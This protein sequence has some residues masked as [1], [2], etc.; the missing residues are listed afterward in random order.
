MFEGLG[1]TFGQMREV[2]AGMSPSRR[3]MVLG[4][5]A[6][7]LAAFIFLM[8]WANK[9]EYETVYAQLSQ[10]DAGAIVAK[11]KER[12]IPYQLTGNGTVI[13]VPK[14]AT[15]ET[16]LFLATEGLP[17][18]GAVGMEVFDR[19]ALGATDFVQR[20]N[21]QRALQ[22]EL[23]RTIRKF[24]EVD[25]VRVHL[26]IPKES[27]F[28]EEARE[29]SASVVLKLKSG[30]ALDR[31]Q[32]AG[33]VHLVSSS[34]EG[35][36]PQN[37]SVVDTQGGLLYSQDPDTDG[38]L[39]TEKQVQFRRNLEKTLADRVTT[40]LERVVGPN[41]AM[42][43]VTAEIS[44][45][46]TSTNEEIYDPDRTAIR[47][48]QRFTETTSGAARGAAGTP[49]ARYDLGTG[50]GEPGTG[51]AAE[52]KYQKNEETT[53]YEITKINR[54]T[55]TPGGEVQRLSVAVIVDGTYKEEVVDGKDVKTFV[56]R[57]QAEIT[58]LEQLV[59]NAVGY[60]ET[61]G[62]AVVVNSVPF[63]L[64]EEEAPVGFVGR[65]VDYLRQFG[66]PALNILLIV[67]FFLFVVRPIMSWVRKEAR[68]ALPAPTEPQALLERED[69]PAMVETRVEPG[70]L[71]REQVLAIAN[72]NPDRTVNMIRAWID[73]R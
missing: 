49:N 15:Q 38:V 35:L 66:R 32:L 43:R 23:E 50:Q 58:S 12:K 53:N 3:I 40:M 25:Q 28:I 24:R 68:Q 42:A 2:F 62:D 11:L 70:K 7:V 52:E 30:Q 17:T 64:P 48:E 59:R 6:A 14:E 37:I 27:L 13:Q 51:T 57:S 20:L 1:A 55:L 18:G 73:Q 41:K 72:Q 67:L 4:G 56:P 26:N 71:S 39:V 46:Q 22:G 16:R 36:K 61:R 65:S 54:Q 47:S 45:Q 21:Y 8:L 5:T 63:Y 31:S 9:P 34:V 44:Y 33:I 10:E 60:D 29:P 19:N 69:A